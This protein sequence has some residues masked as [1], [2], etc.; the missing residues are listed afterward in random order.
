MKNKINNTQKKVGYIILGIVCVTILLIVI[1]GDSW[2]E[3]AEKQKLLTEQAQR[4]DATRA[5]QKAN[6][7]LKQGLI[8]SD[9][10][11]C[12]DLCMYDKDDGASSR[13]CEQVCDSADRLDGSYGTEYMDKRIQSYKCS[14]C[15]ECTEEQLK[16][17]KEKNKQKEEETRLYELR[18]N[19]RL[20][21]HDEASNQIGDEECYVNK[22]NRVTKPACDEII[23]KCIKR[24]KC[25]ELE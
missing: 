9:W 20:K 11:Y 5:E 21:C 16:V 7:C 6:Q 3:A 13:F 8:Q 1:F 14:K 25:N 12:I 15:G 18:E 10:S 22:E 2:D 19:C 23:I 24:E 4:E 17:I